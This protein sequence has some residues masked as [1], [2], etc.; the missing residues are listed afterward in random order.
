[1]VAEIHPASEENIQQAA[2]ILARGGLVAIPTETVYGLAADAGS[3]AAVASLYTAKGRPHFNPLISHVATLEMAAEHG[4]LTD[5]A[6]KLAEH[7]WPGPLTIVVETAQTCRVCDLARAG[8]NSIALRIPAHPVAQGVLEAFGGPLVAPSANPSGQISPTHA[9]HVATD[10]ADRIDF[11][12]DGGPCQQ[13]LE[14]TIIDAR[15][16]HPV[17]LRAGTI[18]ASDIDA[19]W[20]GLVRGSDHPAAPRSPGQLLRHYAPKAALRLN[21]SH[22]AANEALLGFGDI[23]GTSNLSPKGDLTEAAA[24]LFSML[25]QLDAEYHEI[26]VAPIPNEGL[27][28][29][30]NDR[31]RRAAQAAMDA[32]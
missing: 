16:T 12:L 6:V 4:L 23:T 5:P 15:G 22:A 28:E 30:I 1:M 14:S 25:R 11:I 18:S 32:V 10:M 13:G 31:L 29:A 27:G 24:N 26:A 2:G 8:L 21:V 20:P 9:E 7:F 17:M 19:V 3:P